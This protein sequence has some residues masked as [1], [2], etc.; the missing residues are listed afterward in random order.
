MIT[1]IGDTDFDFEPS[2]IALQES[3]VSTSRRQTFQGVGQATIGTAAKEFYFAHTFQILTQC[4]IRKVQCS[5]LFKQVA[6]DVLD[7]GNSIAIN[8]PGGLM[9]APP[10][11]STGA[12]AAWAGLLF[13]YSGAGSYIDTNYDADDSFVLVPNTTY[14][15]DT[16]MYGTFAV[17]DILYI[18]FQIQVE[19]I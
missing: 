5:G 2:N 7:C 15:V 18:R 12:A 19:Y 1:K 11:R 8:G 14:T 9:P 3:R 17:G 13:L 6:G 16:S 10:I 4:R